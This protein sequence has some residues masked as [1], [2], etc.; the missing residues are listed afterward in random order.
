MEH[1]EE[2]VERLEEGTVVVARGQFTGLTIHT[3]YT[4]MT[5]HMY[6][7]IHTATNPMYVYIVYTYIYK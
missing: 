3:I 4:Y 6:T 5:I 2:G 7:F 1:V